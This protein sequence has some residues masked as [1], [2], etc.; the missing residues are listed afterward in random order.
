MTNSVPPW[1]KLPWKT[2]TSGNEVYWSHVTIKARHG[3]ICVNRR[4]KDNTLYPPGYVSFSIYSYDKKRFR[5]GVAP[6]TCHLEAYCL[7]LHHLEALNAPLQSET[8]QA[9]E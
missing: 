4:E 7:L 5:T 2:A 9:A 8:P 6:V 1:D 3:E